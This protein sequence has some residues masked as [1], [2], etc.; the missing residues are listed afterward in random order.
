MATLSVRSIAANCL[1]RSVPL[2]LIT[3]IFGVYGN[4]NQTRSL[5]KQLDLI[6]NKPY[7]RVALVTIQGANPNLQRDLDNANTV[8]QNECDAWIYCAGSI[9]VNQPALQ[10]LSQDDCTM[11]GHSVSQ[12]EDDLFALGRNMGADIV[13]YYIIGDTAGFAGCAA[14]PSGQRGF[15]VGNGA[16]PW[17]FAHEFTHVVGRNTHVGDSNNLMSTPTANITNPPPDLTDAQRDRILDDPAIRR[18]N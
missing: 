7:V 3:D 18:C 5:K 6:R 10:T 17:T 2:S 8:Y 4:N 14:H 1:G 9:I 13:C 16:S 11:N 15:W 12:E